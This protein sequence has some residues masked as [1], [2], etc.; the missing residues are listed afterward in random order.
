MAV[1]ADRWDKL[2]ADPATQQVAELTLIGK[3]GRLTPVEVHATGIVRPDG[4]FAGIHGAT[5][6]IG[7]RERLQ[8]EL[9]G[10]RSATATSSR[11]RR[12]SSG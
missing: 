12:T 10:P 5:R 6:D 4:T 9:R 8:R 1:A 11:R 3:D 7:E 2:V